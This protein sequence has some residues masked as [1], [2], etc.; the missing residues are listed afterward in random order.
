MIHENADLREVCKRLATTYMADCPHSQVL[1]RGK[2]G[3]LTKEPGVGT[4]QAEC[5][6]C[7]RVLGRES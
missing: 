5:V 7:F 4:I 2:D 3:S 6:E 1:W